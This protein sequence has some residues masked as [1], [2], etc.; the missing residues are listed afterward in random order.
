MR[1][2]QHQ[3]KSKIEEMLVPSVKEIEMLIDFDLQHLVAKV[4][5]SK[6]YIKPHAR[7]EGHRQSIAQLIHEEIRNRVKESV[8]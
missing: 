6:D 5:D 8:K 7:I 3:A 1:I 4:T 2:A